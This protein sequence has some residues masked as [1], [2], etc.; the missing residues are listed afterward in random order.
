MRTKKVM[1]LKYKL[2]IGVVVFTLIGVAYYALSPLFRNVKVVEEAPISS[3][4]VVPP[5]LITGTPTH[6]A[7]GSV[8]VLQIGEERTLRYENFKTINGPDLLV[9]LSTDLEATDFVDLGE[10]KATEG[11]VNYTIPPGTDLSKYR[12]ALIWCED[13]S[14]LFNSA[15]LQP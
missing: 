5:R 7:S 6:P 1:K 2:L 4:V 15:D 14:V 3:K 9:Y 11:D 8:S 12:Y 13:F 10:L